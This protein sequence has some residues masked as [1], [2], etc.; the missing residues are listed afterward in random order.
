MQGEE[1]RQRQNPG[2]MATTDRIA[3]TVKHRTRGSQKH[4]LLKLFVV[5]FLKILGHGTFDCLTGF[6]LQ[7]E[8]LSRGGASG[9]VAHP[10][11]PTHYTA[12][13]DLNLSMTKQRKRSCTN[14]VGVWIKETYFN[15]VP[16]LQSFN[17]FCKLY[18]LRISQAVHSWQLV[19]LKPN[20]FAEE[21]HTRLGSIKRSCGH[22]KNTC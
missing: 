3:D 6:E 14:V 12:V 17:F 20:N 10:V 7:G 1:R 16:Y 11:F 5:L 21:V 15:Q 18:S 19:A 8:V 9:H 4:C 22:W 2:P 13:R